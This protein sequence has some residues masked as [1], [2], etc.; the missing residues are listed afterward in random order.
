MSA[1]VPTRVQAGADVRPTGKEPRRPVY[2]V[3]GILILAFMLFPLYWMVNVSLQPAG[4]AVA[5][6]WFPFDFSLRGY[7]TAISEQ[8]RNLVTSLLISL[9]AVVFS[10]LVATPAA[11]AMAHFKLG[12]WATVVLFGILVTQ[13]VPGIVVAN[14][15]Y[16]AY[17]DL[18]CS[19]RC[20]G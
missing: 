3:I 12:R 9:G 8:G 10:L 16:S 15:L 4:N 11:Y 19:T 2:T 6:P 18:G 20:R 17:S 13:M 7:T 14:A 1:V 5:T